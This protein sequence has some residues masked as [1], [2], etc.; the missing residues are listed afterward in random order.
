MW[1]RA[2]Q[3]SPRLYTAMTV[4][5]DEGADGRRTGDGRADGV[6]VRERRSGEGGRRG[7]AACTH[8]GHDRL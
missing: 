6:V 7:G 8:R 1:R 2:R 3:T 5:G 4:D